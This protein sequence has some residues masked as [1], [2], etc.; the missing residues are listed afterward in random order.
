MAVS[1]KQPFEVSDFSMGITDDAFE[2][3]PR[4][5]LE[6]DNFNIEPDA[7]L[8]SR[9]GSVI[10]DEDEPQIPTGVK[11]IGAL[12]NYDNS[13]K[14]FYQSET[15]VYYRNPAAFTALQ[16]PTSNEVF[17][18]GAE[19][20]NIAFSQ[21]NKQLYLTN[22]GFPRPM[23][24][25]KD[26]GG[27]YRVNTSGLP[28]LA[29]APT[30][31]PGVGANSYIYAFHHYYTYTVGSQSFEDVGPITE[32]TV[33]LAIAPESNDINIT[34]I[35]VL[36]NGVTDNWDT[37]NIKIQI[38]RTTNAG[39]TFFKV[40]EVTNG[41]TTFNDST[42][43]ANLISAVKIYTDNGTVE[44]DPTPLHKYVHVVNS[45]GYYG[46]IKV[47]S[48]EYPFKIRQSIPGNPSACPEDFELDLE[49]E[50]TGI[51]SVNSIPIVTCKRHVYRLENNFDIF[52]R[53]GINP[54]R[55]S[56]T[57]GCVSHLSI[58]TA[59]G[60]MFWAG[61][62]GF[63]ATDGYT[64]TKISDKIN[65]RYRLVLEESDDT[66]R[67]Y[68]KFDDRN[69]R[70]Y[71][72]MQSDSS[73][74][75]NDT[76]VN[77]D[78]RWGIRDHSTFTTWSGETFR[79]ATLE[80][81][82]GSLYRADDS[83]YAFYHDSAVY[84]D[85]E[86]DTTAEAE[87]WEEETIMWNYESCS[88]NF[89]SSF[90]RKM[91]TRILMLARNISNTS[92]QISTVD[93]DGKRERFLKIIRWRRNF[94]WGDVNFTWGSPDCV[95]KSLGIIEQWRRF[96][97]RGLRVSF[98]RIK[99][100]NGYSVI[101]NSDTLGEAIFDGSAK[102]ATL[103]NAATND[104]PTGSVGYFISTEQDDYENEY[105][106]NTRTDDVLTYTSASGAIDTETKGW[107][108]KGYK[109][110]EPLNLQGYVIHTADVDQNQITHETGD[111]GA[112]T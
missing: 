59:E 22:D 92:V 3:D 72:A 23:K 11:R 56:D 74:Q 75:E 26:S 109:K 42:S 65:E 71:W 77:L 32:V 70:I 44:F 105:E 49:D 17:S 7:S 34:A 15:K 106:V 91:P 98:I 29:T 86:V 84:T 1:T 99:I 55:I 31:T 58:V 41:T 95:W 54:V 4:Y 79:P 14:L 50:I 51:G 39:T 107:L 30:C 10:E 40:G 13:T 103:V 97:A 93:D 100:T 52:G 82:N 80:M 67:I 73:S 35:P 66:K 81:F 101:S 8:K 102:T 25:Y 37:S 18:I 2:K 68:G 110:G 96:P 43:D 108:L 21:W 9:D 112:N 16:G 33:P 63:Y 78:L 28:A 48:V 53:G 12:I 19:T 38:Y 104:W 94:I 62:D 45:I 61:N 89:G 76:L 20:N 5:A 87:D 47:S 88:L 6:L 83:G 36:A 24:I 85:P 60:K 57:A 111:D 46:F 27:T 69:R 64:V 90:F